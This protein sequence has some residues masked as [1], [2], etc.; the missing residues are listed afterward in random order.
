MGGGMVLQAISN[1]LLGNLLY[2]REEDEDFDQTQMMASV[3]G[4]SVGPERPRSSSTVEAMPPEAS[5][6]G[7]KKKK[8]KK[9]WTLLGLR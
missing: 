3:F 8:K 5:A 2:C 7:Q 4:A 9:R 1:H 6:G